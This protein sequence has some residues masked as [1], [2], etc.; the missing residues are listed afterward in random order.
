MSINGKRDN[1]SKDDLALVSGKIRY[2]VPRNPKSK[3]VNKL[4][5][6]YYSI[7]E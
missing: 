3:F 6:G 7:V 5:P 1:F 2:Y 4:N